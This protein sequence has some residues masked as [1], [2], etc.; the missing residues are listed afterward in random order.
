MWIVQ[1]LDDW[2]SYVELDGSFKK[3]YLG[4]REDG[5]AQVPHELYTRP[6]TA[7]LDHSDPHA[8]CDAHGLLANDGEHHCDEEDYDEDEIEDDA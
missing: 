6:Y 1:L 5:F 2:Q 8:C 4:S 3:R 7:V